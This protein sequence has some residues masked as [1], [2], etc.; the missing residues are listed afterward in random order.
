MLKGLKK[1]T[2]KKTNKQKK[3][4][5]QE[6]HKNK[7]TQGKTYIKSPRRINHKAQKS[8]TNTGITAVERSVEYTN[9]GLKHF[10]GQPTSPWVPMLLLI[11]KYIKIRFT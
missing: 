2:Q 3:K 9:G 4:T 10:Y 1:K 5:T 8:K 7:I 11:Q 6:Q